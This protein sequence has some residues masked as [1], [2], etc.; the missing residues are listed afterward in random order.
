MHG[1]TT[2]SGDINTRKLT[3]SKIYAPGMEIHK[4]DMVI[5][6]N[7]FT[8]TLRPVIILYAIIKKLRVMTSTEDFLCTFLGPFCINHLAYD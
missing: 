1:G 4:T 5:H 3:P 7:A 6:K 8:I 2:V